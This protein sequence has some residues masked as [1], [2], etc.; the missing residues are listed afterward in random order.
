MVDLSEEYLHFN[1]KR[2]DGLP[3][4]S[5]T[6]IEAVATALNVDG[7]CLEHLHP[8]RTTSAIFQAVPSKKAVADGKT[9]VCNRLCRVS[10][11]FDSARTDLEI[12]TPLLAVIR[13]FPGFFLPRPDGRIDAPKRGD[14]FKGRHAVALV[15]LEQ[16]FDGTGPDL[17]VRNS[18][19]PGWGQLGY[20]R[21]A[22]RSFDAHCVQLWR[23]K[24][25]K[26]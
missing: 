10:A 6:T 8:Y 13:L 26:E 11:N 22:E 23:W 24:L 12:G 21:M 7:Q 14:V 4:N 3:V 17:I 2:Q 19:G 9:R 16:Q 18:W 25:G 15:G 1:A 5:G 20:G